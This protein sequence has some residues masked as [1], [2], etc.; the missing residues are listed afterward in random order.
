MQ[1]GSNWDNYDDSHQRILFH[2][3]YKRISSFSLQLIIIF[4]MIMFLKLK[5]HKGTR[6]SVMNA[7]F[8]STQYTQARYNH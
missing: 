1:I 4:I 3:H 7:Y 5:E 2:A 6:Q 8:V